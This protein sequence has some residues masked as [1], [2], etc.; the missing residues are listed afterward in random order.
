[1]TWEQPPRMPLN[2]GAGWSRKSRRA[3]RHRT[4]VPNERVDLLG[5]ALVALIILAPALGAIVYAVTGWVHP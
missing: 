1:M 2:V 5:V 3:M 4:H